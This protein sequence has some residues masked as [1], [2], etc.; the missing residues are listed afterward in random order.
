MVNSIPFFPR[1]I[2][3]FHLKPDAPNS[4]HA[5]KGGLRAFIV[6]AE[7]LAIRLAGGY[8]HSHGE[9]HVLS[10]EAKT[11]IFFTTQHTWLRGWGSFKNKKGCVT[12]ST[13]PR[14]SGGRGLAPPTTLSVVLNSAGPSLGSWGGGKLHPAARPVASTIRKEEMKSVVWGI[15]SRIKRTVG[16]P[17]GSQHFSEDTLMVALKNTIKTT[18][19]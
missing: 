5:K 7:P 1:V 17:G 3:N 15:N 14:L 8:S 6:S 16:L 12:G 10:W 19:A 18:K 2:Y 13:C 4:K 11:D 9:S